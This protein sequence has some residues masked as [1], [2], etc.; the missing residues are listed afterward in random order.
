MPMMN[1]K[2]NSQMLEWKM[3]DEDTKEENMN[4]DW[5]FKV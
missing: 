5:Q 2:S 4:I 1:K 3:I